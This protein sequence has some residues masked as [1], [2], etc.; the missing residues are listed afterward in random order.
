MSKQ[1]YVSH[2]PLCDPCWYNKGEQKK[3]RYDARMT[4]GQGTGTWGNMCEECWKELTDQELGTGHGQELM[5]AVR[6]VTS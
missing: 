1:V 2:I 6:E 3:A 5:L 4:K